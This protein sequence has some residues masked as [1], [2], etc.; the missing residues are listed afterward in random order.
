M[1]T[2]LKLSTKKC[3]CFTLEPVL[4]DSAG[5]ERCRTS[6][7]TAVEMQTAQL[8]VLMQETVAPKDKTHFLP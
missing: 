7:A 1:K 3:T 5:G 2:N 8:P 6:R 4:C